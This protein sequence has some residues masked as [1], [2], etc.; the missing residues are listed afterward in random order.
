MA[1]FRSQ[2]GERINEEQTDPRCA[3]RKE[4]VTF[5][6]ILASIIKQTWR[7]KAYAQTNMAPREIFRMM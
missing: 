7:E 2:Y 3:G 5:S 4:K 1:M 6:E